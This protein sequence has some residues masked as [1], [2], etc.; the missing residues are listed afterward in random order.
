[1][2]RDPLRDPNKYLVLKLP[3]PVRGVLCSLRSGRKYEL[4]EFDI[5]WST[6]NGNS[7]YVEPESKEIG[8]PFLMRSVALKGL[9]DDSLA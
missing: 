2:R 4:S 1:M 3:R 8:S 5:R 6:V 7:T 9:F